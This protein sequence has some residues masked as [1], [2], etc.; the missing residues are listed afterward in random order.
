MQGCRCHKPY[1]LAAGS[2][3]GRQ[4]PRSAAPWLVCSGSGMEEKQEGVSQKI[5][6]EGERILPP[7]SQHCLAVNGARETSARW[8]QPWEDT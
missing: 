6:T 5:C 1:G 2:G 3:A 8:S 7:G 4:P